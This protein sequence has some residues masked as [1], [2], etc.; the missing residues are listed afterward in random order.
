VTDY[1]P[2]YAVQVEE[3]AD[4]ILAETNDPAI[5][6]NALLW[7]SQ[8]IAACFRAAARPDALAA[9]ID[10]WV[11]TRQSTQFFELTVDDPPLGAWQLAAI[12]TSRR[13]EEPLRNIHATLGNGIPF[14]Q[15][16]VEEFA[17][18]HPLTSLYFDRPSIATDYIESIKLPTPELLDVVGGLNENL[19]DLRKLTALYADFLPKQSRWQAEL[20]LLDTVA[21]QPVTTVLQDLATAARAADRAATTVESMPALVERER[22]AG[23]QILSAE[24]QAAFVELERMRSDT[25][26]TL[27][28]ER[29][30]VLAALREERE[31]TT[32]AIE[33]AAQRSLSSVDERVSTHAA[34]LA[35]RGSVI[36]ESAG[37]RALQIV[38][39]V[40]VVILGLV[41]SRRWQSFRSQD[42]RPIATLPLPHTP[43]LQRPQR[44]SPRNIA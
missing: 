21:Q 19:S 39:I 25:L 42:S 14:G 17:V 11:L 15:S 31:L 5:R 38:L 10:T 27:R 20:L 34:H 40:A 28:D 30:A 16:F 41:F 12:E 24:R 1:V 44:R 35:E 36:F 22:L 18:K 7:K 4:R 26:A 2:R 9:L 32:T 33:A 37:R 8:G 3:A 13:L 6:R 29:L 43:E 23:Q